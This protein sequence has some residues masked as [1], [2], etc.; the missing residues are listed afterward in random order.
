MENSMGVPFT[1]RALAIDHEAAICVKVYI[2]VIRKTDGTGGYTEGEVQ[3]AFERMNDIY[4]DN[5]TY[6]LNNVTSA[7]LMIVDQNSGV[8]QNYIL[9]PTTSATTI[10]L[11]NY[12]TGLYTIALVC[13]SDIMNAFNFIKQ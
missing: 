6:K 12:T 13:D 11:D 5:G 7:Y 2:H 3:D 10:T 4:I 9:D 8:S 1:N